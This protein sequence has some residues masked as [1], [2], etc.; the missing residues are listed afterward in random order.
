[1]PLPPG[2]TLSSLQS[3]DGTEISVT[4]TGDGPP[5]VLVPGSLGTAADWQAVAD[6]LAPSATAYVIDRRGRAASGDHV[7]YSLQRE[8]E[9]ISAVLGE[10]GPEAILFGHSYG[11]LISL[12]LATERPL[13]GLVLYE[14]GL[15]LDGPVAG[16]SLKRF[17]DL[18]A[19]GDLH[20]ALLFG[21]ETFVGLTPDE[22]AA[23]ASSPAWAKLV[24]MTPTWIR[25]L[26]IIDSYS[27]NLERLSQ[28]A[29]PT[30]MMAGEVSPAWLVDVSRQVHDALPLS[31]FVTL[32]GQGH[33][34][35]ETAPA[36][37]ASE[38]LEFAA[39]LRKN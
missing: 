24:P 6:A 32:D 29:V 17:S 22:A 1:M 16:A 33:G 25:E 21:V 3:R 10:A 23:F 38:L 5:I 30:T 4:V 2:P 18:V 15:A 13:A 14:P 37:V 27:V 11:A 34:A 26:T 36:L 8:L 39:A 35:N 9:D 12:A 7:E 19:T 31:R 20:A 28:L